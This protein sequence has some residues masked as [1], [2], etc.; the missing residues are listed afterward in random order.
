MGMSSSIFV[1]LDNRNVYVYH[2]AMKTDEIVQRIASLE[3]PQLRYIA[4]ETGISH[5][6]LCAMKYGRTTN[7]TGKTCDTLREYFEAHDCKD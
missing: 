4:A 5:A 3:Q 2:H 6:T 1:C 7:P